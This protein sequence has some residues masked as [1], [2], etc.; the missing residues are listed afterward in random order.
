[1]LYVSHEIDEILQLTDRVMILDEGLLV[2][3]GRYTDLAL[4]E[5][6]L[7]HHPDLLNVLDAVV[8]RVET[9][10]T[11]LRLVGASPPARSSEGVLRASAAPV[12]RQ[13]LNVYFDRESVGPPP[14]SDRQADSI[15]WR[16]QGIVRTTAFR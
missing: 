15:P 14:P 9:G 8:E 16:E 5:A 4:D 2:G 13:V 12:V 10:E 1:M 11:T 3:L 6:V 7:A